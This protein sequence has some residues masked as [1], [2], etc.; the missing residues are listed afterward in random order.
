MGD[1]K[2][3]QDTERVG[4]MAA[5][6]KTQSQVER[7][8]IRGFRSFRDIN[9]GLSNLTVMIGANGS[10]KSNFIKFFEML[11]WMLKGRNLKGF[12]DKNGGADDQLF[13]GSKITPHLEAEIHIRTDQGR[14]DYAFSFARGHPDRFHFMDEK[15]RF[16][17]SGYETKAKWHEL[18][19]GGTESGLAAATQEGTESK[20]RTARTILYLLRDNATFQFHDTS[21]GSVFKQ[22]WD[23]SDT[24]F[25]LGNG[26]NT[27]AI[28]HRL[29]QENIKLYDFICHIIR[30]ALPGFDR[31]EL[32]VTHGSM[33]P[34][35]W[36]SRGSDKTFGAH[37]T[38]DG[39]LRFFALTTLL[40]LPDDMLPSMILLDEP[41]LGLHPA[42]INLIGSMIKSLSERKQVIVATQSP[43]LVDQFSL[44]NLLVL[45]FDEQSTIFRAINKDDYK[46]WLDQELSPAD[47]WQKNILGGR[48]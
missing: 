24:A 32:D 5:T 30:L 33:P 21:D 40:N 26:S 34:L 36:K 10:G 45:D 11:S 48:P 12:V 19:G 20:K 16:C 14:N 9:V 28:L 38:S 13:L 41:E 35:R 15:F 42:A 6:Q 3:R 31:F 37:L 46:V 47:L 7:V 44:D 18:D 23:A 29:V 8:R 25:L 39:S 22:R 2:S 43:L 4:E 1:P 27:A 17:K